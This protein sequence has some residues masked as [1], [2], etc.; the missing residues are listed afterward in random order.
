[1]RR[2]SKIGRIRAHS[3]KKIP[4]EVA[5]VLACFKVGREPG[6]TSVEVRSP[7]YTAVPAYAA[8]ATRNIQ[9]SRALLGDKNIDKSKHELTGTG[10]DRY[11]AWRGTSHQTRHRKWQVNQWL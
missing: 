5:R 4:K 10:T 8:R 1:M 3:A 9:L 7:V 11:Q 6:E 2:L